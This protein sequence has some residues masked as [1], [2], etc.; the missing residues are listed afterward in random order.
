M[1]L[2]RYDNNLKLEVDGTMRMLRLMK[3]REIQREVEGIKNKSNW[4]KN[5]GFTATI[6]VPKTIDYIIVNKVI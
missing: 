1:I 3:E 6:T 5:G 4:F 2:D